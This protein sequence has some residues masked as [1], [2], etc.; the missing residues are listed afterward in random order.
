MI[1]N[2]RFDGDGKSEK[3]KK[4][5][6]IMGATGAGKSKLSIDLASYFSGVE[7]VNA[8]SMQVFHPLL[9]FTKYIF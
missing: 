5:V 1:P 6:V 2:P 8:D 9:L 7:I 3:K 4:V